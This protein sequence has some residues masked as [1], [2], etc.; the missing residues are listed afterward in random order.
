MCTI[1]YTSLVVILIN[2]LVIYIIFKT[3]TIGVW[4]SAAIRLE[5]NF[6]KCLLY[7]TIQKRYIKFKITLLS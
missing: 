3:I 6:K 4:H 1:V 7:Y 2:F 5:S